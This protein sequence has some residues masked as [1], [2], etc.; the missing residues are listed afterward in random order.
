MIINPSRLIFEL[1]PVFG[2]LCAVMVCGKAAL[3][4][5]SRHYRFL[6]GWATFNVLL[7]LY[8]Q[9]S[10]MFSI[11]VLNSLLGTETANYIWTIHN[12]S[13]SLLAVYATNTNNKFLK[14]K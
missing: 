13:W 7:M 10:W 8:A 12:T 9:S 3:F 2:A 1:I 11:T 14:Y 4:H 6:C 5:R